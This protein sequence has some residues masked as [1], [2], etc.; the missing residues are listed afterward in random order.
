MSSLLK[1]WAHQSP[2]LPA[3]ITPTHQYT[4]RELADKVDQ[5]AAGL[6]QQGIQAGH[7]IT[8]V[9]KNSVEQLLVY[10]ACLELGAINALTMPQT[11]SELDVKLATLYQDPRESH[12]WFT[13]PLSPAPCTATITLETEHI[14]QTDYTYKT[15]CTYQTDHAPMSLHPDAQSRYDQDALASIVFTSGS[16]GT[17]KAVAHCSRQHLAS[18]QGLLAVFP[19]K[20][21]DCWLLSLPLYH[22]SGLAIVYRWLLSGAGLKVGSGE[23]SQ[24]I[25]GVT[26]ASLVATQLR[27][28]LDSAQP[29]QLKQVL[30]GG[31]H[32]D[33]GLSQ[34]AAQRGIETWLGY[35]LTEAASTVTA[36]R[37][38]STYSAGR[39][40]AKRRLK[41]EGQ[42]IY[43]GG[44]TLASGYYQCGQLTPL[45]VN[46]WFD[47]KDLGEWVG[48]ELRIIGRADNQ[49]ISGGENIHCEEIEQVLNRHP[50]I[51]FAIVVPVEDLEFG[52]RPVAVIITS[53]GF[54]SGI[55]PEYLDSQLSRFKWPTAYYTMP[56]GLS[57]NG[58]KISRHAV[59]QWLKLNYPTQ[60]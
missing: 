43:I 12:V 38:D 16:T 26:H 2:L 31:G 52:H 40:L 48:D 3:L 21:G 20:Q 37:V 13:Q 18:A 45:T 44:E 56:A 28:L 25:Q 15:D 4:W 14:F 30:L 59:K 54:D 10:L 11:K 53:D 36:K 33:H 57:E 47:T 32:V 8:S 5:V 49:F 51:D 7:V 42:S 46:G 41:L 34:Q 19:F 9:G 60:G 39:L 58:I 27:R 55:M 22:V 23:L 29:L 6:T 35:G 50:M 1:H 24:D 17:P